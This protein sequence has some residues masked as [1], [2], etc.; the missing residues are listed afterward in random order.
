[1]SSSFSSDEDKP[2]IWLRVLVT[3][4]DSEVL[5]EVDRDW[6]VAREKLGLLNRSSS[7][8]SEAKDLFPDLSFLGVSS[9]KEGPGLSPSS[10]SE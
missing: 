7:L 6:D 1:M 5:R 4:P 2:V 3:A 10:S 9:K 8:K